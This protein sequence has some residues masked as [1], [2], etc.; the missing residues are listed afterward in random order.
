MN[1][2]KTRNLEA[3]QEAARIDARIKAKLLKRARKRIEIW[4]R[5]AE[6]IDRK[7]HEGPAPS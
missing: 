5:A 6:R 3:W 1:G 7:H 4:K 2:L